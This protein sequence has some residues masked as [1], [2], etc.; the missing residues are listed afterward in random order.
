MKVVSPK[1]FNRVANEI[2]ERLVK[3][4]NQISNRVTEEVKDLTHRLSLRDVEIHGLR[5]PQLTQKNV[6]QYQFNQLDLSFTKPFS[7][8]YKIVKWVANRLVKLVTGVDQNLKQFQDKLGSSLAKYKDSPNELKKVLNNAEG[9]NLET[10]IDFHQF[11]TANEDFINSAFKGENLNEKT[12][13]ALD[14]LQKQIDAHASEEGASFVDKSKLWFKKTK[15]DFEKMFKTE[16]A[17][18]TATA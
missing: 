12:N 10:I 9:E 11:K 6:Y 1:V 15:Y 4:E 16:G 5:N 2:G 3:I 7:S 13:N 14:L 18:K 17:T 8:A